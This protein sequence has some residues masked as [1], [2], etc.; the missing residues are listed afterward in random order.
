MNIAARLAV[1][2]DANGL[3]ASLGASYHGLNVVLTSL[4][5]TGFHAEA[6]FACPKGALVRLRLPCVGVALARVTKVRRGILEGVFLNPVNPDRLSK[7]LGASSE[8][9]NHALA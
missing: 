1:Q 2:F 5:S 6:S 3:P 8:M 9:R 7:V 4:N